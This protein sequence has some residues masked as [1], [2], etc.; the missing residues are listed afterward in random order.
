MLSLSSIRR[1][2][3]FTEI[4]T[5]DYYTEGGERLGEW[6]VTGGDHAQFDGAVDPTELENVMAGWS[7]DKSSRLTQPHPRRQKGWDL[8]FSAPKSVSV[9][10]A[11][12]PKAI[13]EKILK[14][15]REAVTA[16]LQYA[17]RKALWTRRGKGGAEFERVE[18][19]F[20]ALITHISS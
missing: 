11:L 12:A 6:L 8:T 3:Y 15:H 9:F 2:G 5:A 10:Y 19:A 4:A 14:A 20:F 16:G 17:V 7:R 1:P 13:R 18:K